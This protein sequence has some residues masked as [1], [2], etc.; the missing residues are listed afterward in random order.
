MTVVTVVDDQ[1]GP[2]AFV[3][4][5]VVGAFT[6]L[7]AGASGT[8]H[9]SNAGTSAWCGPDKVIG[10]RGN[11]GADR[12]QPGTTD[13]F[14]LPARRPPNSV[15]ESVRLDDLGLAPLSDYHRSLQRAVEQLRSRS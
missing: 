13:K 11:L 7:E 3:D 15:L 12:V 4:N 9:L 5:L 8:L 6:A 10:A 14:A 1:H 2:T